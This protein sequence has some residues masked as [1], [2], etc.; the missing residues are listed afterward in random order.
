M[1][2]LRIFHY[3]V[4]S[5]FLFL[6]SALTHHQ[7][8]QFNKYQQLSQVNRI[9]IL[10]Q[11]ARRGCILDR[12]GNILAGNVISYN[13]LIMPE[14]KVYP[15]EKITKLS[16]LLSIPEEKLKAKYLQGHLT[17]FVPVLLV[18][19]ISLSQAVAIGQLKY[20][21]PEVTIQESPKRIYP[22]GSIASHILGYLGNIDIWRWEQ[23]KEYGYKMQD[24]IG[25]SGTE[26]VYDYILRPHD[27]GMQVEVDSKGRLSRI[28]GFKS[29]QKGRD[30]ELTID[31]NLQRIMHDN[32]IGHTGCVIVLNPVNGEVLALASF[33]NFDPRVFQESDPALI[34]PLLNDLDAP[35]LNRA[36]NGLYPP[37]SVFKI[38]VAAAG[39]ESGKINVNTNVL[40]SGKMQIGNRQFH[41]WD[42]HKQENIIDALA[43]SCNVFFYT[44]GLNLG[45]QLINEYALKFGLNQITGIDLSGESKGFLPHS[46]WQ[47]IKR[48]RRWFAGDTANLS[49]G[50]G[51]TLVTPLQ[52]TRIM[53]AIAN[54]GKLIQP[55][56]LKSKDNV[57]GGTDLSSQISN[58]PISK[59]NLEIIRKGLLGAVKQPGGTASVLD[60]LGILIAGKTGTA[61]VA[62]GTAHG[63]FVGYFPTNEPRFVICV[64][65]E[66]AGSGHY[67]CQL[68][69]KIIQQMLAEGLI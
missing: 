38:I 5:G 40:C 10:P 64:F 25:Y 51:Q 35:L 68:T 58:L 67:A 46:L 2:R 31:L 62:Q 13:L 44:L 32:L 20:D 54:G 56:L 48:A 24:L 57:T 37:G 15:R 1:T 26:E 23:L 43:H 28:L 36:I 21:L 33:P 34:N 12:N 52:V 14:Q 50:Q 53:A 49:I 59:E 66:H 42:T 45:P 8:I 4:I 30:I 9:R 11:A 22:L 61:Q 65:L 47:R 41:C 17:P 6:G 19:D 29:P 39:L 16:A 63:W 3:L 69:K 60:G 55:R 27:G 18:K 7:I